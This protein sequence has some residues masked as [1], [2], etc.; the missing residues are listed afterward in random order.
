MYLWWKDNPQNIFNSAED[1]LENSV[2]N[3][4]GHSTAAKQYSNL[5]IENSIKTVA[6]KQVFVSYNTFK[7]FSIVESY[8]N[9][10]IELH[11]FM[12]N[13]KQLPLLQALEKVTDVETFEE[14][15]E[16]ARNRVDSN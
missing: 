7:F 5:G 11:H 2:F 12:G 10:E 8:M 4:L 6:Q 15:L 13:Y 9:G 1:L 14:W 16:T 3:S